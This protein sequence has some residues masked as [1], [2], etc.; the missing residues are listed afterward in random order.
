[1][2]ITAYL[3]NFLKSGH[4]FKD[5]IVLLHSDIS[6]LYKKLKKEKFNFNID[7]LTDFLLNFS[8]KFIFLNSYNSFD[9]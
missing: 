3:D 7:D 2:K 5:D 8:F 1:M 6:Q 4:I 9:F